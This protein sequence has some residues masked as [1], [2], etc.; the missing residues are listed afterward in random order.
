MIKKIK[1]NLISTAVAMALMPALAHAA[2]A[3]ITVDPNN[4]QQS[5]KFAADIKLTLKGVA[6]GNTSLVLDRFIELGMDMLRVPI[7]M[8][9]DIND[10]F[11]DKV[12]D[13]ADQAEDKG[14]T[15]FASVANGDGDLNNNLHHADKFDSSFFCNCAYN[16]YNLNLTKY[17]AYLDDYVENM[18][19]NDAKVNI[20][21]PYNEDTAD[22]S[23][24]RKIWD[25]M[26]NSDFLR[27]GVES[28]ALDVAPTTYADVSNRI[29]IAGAHFYDDGQFARSTHDS[30][31]SN[32]TSATGTAPGWFTESTRLSVG[33]NTTMQNVVAGLEHIIPAIR[34][35][36]ERV[37]VY[38]TAN[39]LVWYNGGTVAYKFSA[40]KQ[41]INNS[42]GNVVASSADT[43]DIRTVSFKNGNNVSINITNPS[44]VSKSVN[45]ILDSNYKT[46][47]LVT[48]TVWETGSEGVANSY[49][50]NNN[51]QWTV[52]VPAESYVHLDVPVKV[53]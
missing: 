37:V 26:T 11:Y 8:T 12:Y 7:Y 53:N 45:V 13:V 23:D 24:Y 25:Q 14:M 47:G 52:T 5:V 51:A 49:T 32:F 29:D 10:I 31:W 2:D 48:R 36:V 22:N 41:F 19:L 35:G 43:A 3:E 9:R 38:Q 46:D 27:I 18:A 4:V 30:L 39:R 15:I 28:W 6:D 16:V 34:G 33:G 20:L 44:S 21:G 40:F 17:A 50:L 42:T 1:K